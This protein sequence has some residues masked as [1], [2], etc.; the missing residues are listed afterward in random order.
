[1]KT[2]HKICKYNSRLWADNEFSW[3]LSN[4]LGSLRTILSTV[5]TT[6]NNYVICRCSGLTVVNV[7]HCF[8]TSG[9]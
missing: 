7:L 8:G 5:K 9:P 6:D 3:M 4:T 2:D 1:M